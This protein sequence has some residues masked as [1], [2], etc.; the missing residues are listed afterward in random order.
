M[1]S[2]IGFLV[3]GVAVVAMGFVLC[4]PAPAQEQGVEQPAARTWTAGVDATVFS[5]YMWRGL[6][7][8]DT[9]VS[10]SIFV[11]F[12]SFEIRATGIAETGEDEGLGEVDASFEY[13]FSVGQLDF[14]AGYMFYGYDESVYS[15]TSEIFGKAS[16]NTGTP[17]T[18]LLE[19]YWDVDEADA[20]Y[21]RIGVA[22]ADRIEKISYALRATL[23]AAT[24]GFGETY[25]FVSESGFIDFDISFS[26]II[27]VTDYFSVKPFV[28]YSVLVNNGIN[29]VVKDD[30]K[31]YAGGAIL[32]MF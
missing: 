31:A 25:F 18:P 2:R 1:V 3:A 19:L 6:N 4:A 14:S 26:M 22:Y 7:K 8:Y 9:A 29:D 30:S 28:G 23:G 15:D 21:G 17:I 10:P 20:L 13:F 5:D 27:P 32:L 11:R 12:P 24:E 16:W